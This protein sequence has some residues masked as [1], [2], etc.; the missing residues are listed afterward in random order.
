MILG[1]ATSCVRVFDL[2]EG[3]VCAVVVVGVCVGFVGERRA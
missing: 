2:V 3:I 1:I